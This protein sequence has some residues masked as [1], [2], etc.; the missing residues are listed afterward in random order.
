MEKARKGKTFAGTDPELK[1]LLANW[2]MS[3]E[4]AIYE[5]FG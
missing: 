5:W 1:G 3:V 4:N 2:E